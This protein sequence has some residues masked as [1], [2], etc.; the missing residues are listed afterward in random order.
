MQISYMLI[1]LRSASETDKWALPT[2]KTMLRT[3]EKCVPGVVSPYGEG[4]GKQ[5][6]R[7]VSGLQTRI[8][9]KGRIGLPG[10]GKVFFNKSLTLLK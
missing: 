7:L 6:L 5:R 1:S 4:A 2:G 9:S 3:L 10:V 8:L